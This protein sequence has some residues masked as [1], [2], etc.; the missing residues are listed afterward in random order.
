MGN[1][2]SVAPSTPYIGVV[3]VTS[4][5][6]PLTAAIR[7]VMPA[8]RHV[9]YACLPNH[10]PGLCPGASSSWEWALACAVKTVK[11]PRVYRTGTTVHVWL[12]TF[13]SCK[14]VTVALSVPSNVNHVD[15][16]CVCLC[17]RIVRFSSWSLLT[18]YSI[19]ARHIHP[20]GLQSR[21]Q[22]TLV[23]GAESVPALAS[24]TRTPTE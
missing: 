6:E 15:I 23:Q 17:K 18:Y 8:V 9:G 12:C 21:D 7:R 19:A 4:S 24:G 22:P 14:C 10:T 3:V 20:L 5:R 2:S 13:K 1:I 16:L 11:R